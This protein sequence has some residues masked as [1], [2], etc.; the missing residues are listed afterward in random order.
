MEYLP[1]T[2]HN[3]S[4]KRWHTPSD[5]HPVAAA[6]RDQ[7]HIAKFLTLQEP[8]EALQR[9]NSSCRTF[10]KIRKYLFNLIQSCSI[11][12]QDVQNRW[13]WMLFFVTLYIFDYICIYI[14]YIY[15][16]IIVLIIWTFF[17][18]HKKTEMSPWEKNDR[19]PCCRK[20]S[21]S[22]GMGPRS[23]VIC[24]RLWM[25]QRPKIMLLELRWNM[26]KPYEIY[27][28]KILFLLFFGAT[29]KLKIPYD[30]TYPSWFIVRLLRWETGH[31]APF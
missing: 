2:I 26:V 1:Q 21:P 17:E 4:F 20:C 15:I 6:W 30:S 31:A 13:T 5:E 29:L 11:I 18:T 12:F 23:L 9:K 24:Q 8:A 14:L 7:G 10:Q 16:Y 27:C 3:R 25:R 19:P 22:L 28:D